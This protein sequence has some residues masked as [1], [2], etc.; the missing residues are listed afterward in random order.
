MGKGRDRNKR[1]LPLG[2]LP[3]SLLGEWVFSRAEVTVSEVAF[4]LAATG[5]AATGL[6]ADWIKL[7]LVNNLASN[8]VK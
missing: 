3:R 4:G 2:R 7:M 5:L 1:V 8:F 6:V